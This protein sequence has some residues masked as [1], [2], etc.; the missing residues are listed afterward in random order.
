M[1]VVHGAGGGFNQGIDLTSALAGRGYQL[2]AP[3]RFG[4]L[5]LT[6]PCS[7]TT[8]MQADAYTESING[9]SL[10]ANVAASIGSGVARRP[11][12]CLM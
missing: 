2:L 6:L 12:S 7:L 9:G 3:S 11:V 10:A 8:A 1:L 4:Y 5:R